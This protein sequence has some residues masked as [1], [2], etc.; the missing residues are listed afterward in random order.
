MM[1]PSSSILLRRRGLKAEKQPSVETQN[2]QRTTSCSP[3]LGEDLLDSEP[4]DAGSPSKSHKPARSVTSFQKMARLFQTSTPASSSAVQSAS[5]TEPAP[6]KAVLA[7]RKL[8]RLLCGTDR[9]F[10]SSL[11]QEVAAASAFEDE[12]PDDVDEYYLPVLTELAKAYLT[13]LRGTTPVPT[14]PVRDSDWVDLS[15]S[16]ERGIETTEEEKDRLILVYR[17]AKNGSKYGKYVKVK[18]I[19]A[20]DEIS[21]LPA[22]AKR[23]AAAGVSVPTP[24]TDQAFKGS[25]QQQ[26]QPTTTTDAATGQLV[27]IMSLSKA[28]TAVGLA[29]AWGTVGGAFSGRS[30][31]GCVQCSRRRQVG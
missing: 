17:T 27:T 3:L 28:A 23:G 20:G 5:S 30:N 12:L 18:N 25:Q 26:Q 24:S 29:M 7:L 8:A 2:L 13:D 11:L 6:Q 10:F 9:A 14:A 1:E 31:R 22:D 19:K 16:E 15:L 4:T 21:Q